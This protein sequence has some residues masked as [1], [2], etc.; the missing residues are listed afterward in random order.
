MKNNEKRIMELEKCTGDRETARKVY[1]IFLKWEEEKKSMLR[2][3]QMQGIQKARDKGVTLGR[4]KLDLPT[5][6]EEIKRE[7]ENGNIKVDMAARCCGMGISTFYRRVKGNAD[8]KR[9]KADE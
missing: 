6:F 2:E 3:K 1:E 5:N 4:P 7:W 8:E 9:D